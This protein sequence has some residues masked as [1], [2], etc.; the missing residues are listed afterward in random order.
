MQCGS[1]QEKKSRKTIRREVRLGGKFMSDWSN[2][3]DVMVGTVMIVAIIVI[4]IIAIKKG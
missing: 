3:S 2:M 1:Q 4:G